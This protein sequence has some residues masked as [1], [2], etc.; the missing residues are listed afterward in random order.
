MVRTTLVSFNMKYV[1]IFAIVAGKLAL[2][3]G[4][5]GTKLKRER[6]RERERARVRESREKCL[7][8]DVWKPVLSRAVLPAV[9]LILLLMKKVAKA[10]G[11]Y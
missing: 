1:V 2:L 4:G 6:E 11:R 3:I 10:T 5:C 8:L 9:E 7:R